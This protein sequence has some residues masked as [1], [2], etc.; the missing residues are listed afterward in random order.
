V[1]RRYR[2]ETLILETE[3]ETVGGRVLVTDFMP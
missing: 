1:R 2:P 3:I